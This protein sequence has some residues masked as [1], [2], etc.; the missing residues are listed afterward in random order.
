VSLHV[1]VGAPLQSTSVDPESLAFRRGLFNPPTRSDSIGSDPADRCPRFTPSWSA[2]S[3]SIEPF[4]PSRW[5]LRRTRGSSCYALSINRL[6]Q[7]SPSWRRDST[8][9][10]K[11]ATQFCTGNLGRVCHRRCVLEVL[12]GLVDLPPSLDVSCPEHLTRS[13]RRASGLVVCWACSAA[14]R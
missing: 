3:L 11:Q 8:D 14:W 4:G 5:R 7:K 12:D 1:R 9:E 2:G 13:V 10:A 6:R